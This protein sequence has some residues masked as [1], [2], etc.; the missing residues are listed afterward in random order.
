MKIKTEQLK[1][2]LETVKPGL[3]NKELIEQST[4]FA[5]LKDKIVT[6]NDEISISYPMK[7]DIQGAIKAD[8]LYQLLNKLNKEE[9][10]ITVTDKEII[11][12]CGRTKAGLIL[13]QEIKLPLEEIEE[14]DK[15]YDLPE[16]FIKYMRFAMTSCSKD[17]SRPKLTCVHVNKNGRIEASD[18]S[19]IIQCKLEKKLPVDTFLIPAT[20]VT[21]LVKLNP[22]QVASG[23]SWVH[24]KTDERAVI[25]CRTFEDS[26]PNIGQHLNVEGVEITLPKITSDILDRAVVFAKR[27]HIL[28]EEVSITLNNNRIKI[29]A[30]SETGGWFEEEANMKYNDELI[31]FLISPYLLKDILLETQTC[32]ICENRLKFNGLNWSYVT[33]LKEKTE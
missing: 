8:E 29:E 3:A 19:R 7:L 30:R 18:D 21:Q 17:F 25:S 31:A 26:F 6:Y 5:F 22:T 28:D 14:Q 23:K 13:Q 20:S 12:Q 33:V 27:D 4:S 32:I 1:H 15:W 10:D 9:I 2:A 11:I 24:F 16:D